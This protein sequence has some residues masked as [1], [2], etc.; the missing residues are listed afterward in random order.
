[1]PKGIFDE[2]KS[3][4]KKPQNKPP[5]P[6]PIFITTQLKT[7]LG[8]LRALTG[9]GEQLFPSF[10]LKKIPWMSKETVTTR[11]NRAANG[12]YKDKQDTHGF[13]VSMSTHLNTVYGHIPKAE[14]A[15]ELMQLRK[16]DGT[17][18]RKYDKS[19]HWELQ[20]ELWQNWANH[21]ESLLPRPIAEIGLRKE[22]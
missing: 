22:T 14:D 17:V 7:V 18:R 12:I 21:L 16:P 15:V 2:P 9:N 5:K 6:H 20:C 1:M 8:N 3:R 4:T 13:R 11:I 19:T 10:A